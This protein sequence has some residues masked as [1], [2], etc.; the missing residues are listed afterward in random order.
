LFAVNDAAAGTSIDAEGMAMAA[1]PGKS[2]IS[3]VATF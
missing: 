3:R 1:R 2:G